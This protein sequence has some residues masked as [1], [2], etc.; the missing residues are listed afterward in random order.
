MPSRSWR[1]LLSQDIQHLTGAPFSREVCWPLR[2]LIGRWQ[3]DKQLAPYISEYSG[4]PSIFIVKF[5]IDLFWVGADIQS[6]CTPRKSMQ[7]H[8][9]NLMVLPHNLWVILAE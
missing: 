1:D 5:Q 4:L 6:E 8:E 2:V 3:G 9:A 7:H